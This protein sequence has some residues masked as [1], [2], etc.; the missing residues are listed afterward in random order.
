MIGIGGKDDC[1]TNHGM[2]DIDKHQDEKWNIGK[3]IYRQN[4]HLMQ[5]INETKKEGS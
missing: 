2:D 1:Q 5:N 4:K 3:L